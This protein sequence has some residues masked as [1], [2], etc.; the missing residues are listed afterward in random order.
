MIIEFIYEGKSY[1]YDSDSGLLTT[2]NRK[3]IA[4]DMNHHFEFFL[5]YR[6]L[7]IYARDYSFSQN[8]NH[9][10]NYSMIDLSL[11]YVINKEELDNIKSIYSLLEG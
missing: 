2:Y 9:T 8:I 5:S 6:Y 10:G 7:I 4:A 3:Y 1:K 11:I